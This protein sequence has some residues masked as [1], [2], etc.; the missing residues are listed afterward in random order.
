VGGRSNE[1]SDTHYFPSRVKNRET[2]GQRHT[3]V[4]QRVHSAV[5]RGKGENVFI[6]ELQAVLQVDDATAA[7]SSRCSSSRI[8]AEDFSS[9]RLSP[10]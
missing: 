2:R 3:N 7:K 10:R 9:C 5:I 1:L 8:V 6:D 4:A